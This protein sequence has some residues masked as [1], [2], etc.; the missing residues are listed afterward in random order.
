[1][2]PCYIVFVILLSSTVVNAQNFTG[3]FDL[4]VSQLYKN[5]KES[6][7]TLSYYFG[8]EKTALVIHARGNQPDLRLVFHE[9]DSTITGLYEQQG[10]K[11][12][13]ILPMNKKYWPAMQYALTDYGTGPRTE[14][15]TTTSQKKINDTLCTEM[16]C[17]NEAYSGTLWVAD[18]IE[19]SFVQ[20][21]AYQGVGAGEDISHIEM[22]ANCGV[23]GF[24]MQMTLKSKLGKADV[25]LHVENL[26]D[27][28]PKG[29]FDRSEHQ[30]SDLR[31]Q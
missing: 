4:I 23:Q 18:E 24:V 21:L 25:V 12:G 8:T 17:D 19:L 26:R 9:A 22:I 13:Y 2:K 27:T 29:I 28:V 6:V 10:K 20:V 30:L 5:G 7:D 31:K 3:S 1:M 15:T 11:G 14:L 16:G